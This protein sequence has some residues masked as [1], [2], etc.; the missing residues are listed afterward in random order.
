MYGLKIQE[1]VCATCP[2][3]DCL[4][5]C[6]YMKFDKEEAHQEM[7]KVVRRE[8]SRVLK[9]CATCYA[10]EEYCPRGN[11][12]FYLIS[13]RRE[14]RGIY[15]APRPITNQWIN[16]TLMQGKYKVGRVKDRALSCCFIPDLGF[17]GAG[18]IFKE[19]APAMVFGAEFMCPAVHTHFAKMSVVRERLPVVLDNFRKLGVKE[20]ICLHDECYGTYTSIAPA[21]GMEVPFKP[22]YYMDFLLE[23]LDGFKD[24]IKPLGIRAAYQRPCSN[25][26]IP[27]KHRLAGEILD[28]IGVEV[29]DRE[30]QDKNALCCGEV[31]R[32]I[33]GYR[34]ANDV[35]Q[36]NIEDMVKA[37]A[38]Y[39]VFNCPACQVSL[40][41]K[42]A[43]AGLKPVHIIDLCKMAVG[44]KEVP[45]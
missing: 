21:Y 36:R 10:C 11:H 33:S 42:V 34:L 5:K 18:E 23:R 29:P 24:R 31:L 28:L 44:E 15:T 32:T 45:R 14:E 13:E 2:S 7:M 9:E 40:S 37:G 26:L 17:L 30:Y 19:V 8:D 6:Q 38:E 25:R 27:D 39:C 43:K 12:P 3:A 1:K 41:K 16:M 4:L 35:Q 20:V 22:V